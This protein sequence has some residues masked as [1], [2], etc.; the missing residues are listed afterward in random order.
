MLT[1]IKIVENEIILLYT[2]WNKAFSFDLKVILKTPQLN[3]EFWEE[4]FISD[5]NPL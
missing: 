3:F 4:K 5:P 2:R 1:L